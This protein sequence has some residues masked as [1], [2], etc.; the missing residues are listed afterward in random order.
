[1]NHRH[2]NSEKGYSSAAID[3][4]ISRGGLA[5]WVELRTAAA[6]D[7][8]ILDRIIRV[9]APRLVDPYE[10][11]YHLWNYHARHARV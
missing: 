7:H 8:R 10:Q 9:C 11:R 5:D 3:D 4:I 2:L 1:M 6:S